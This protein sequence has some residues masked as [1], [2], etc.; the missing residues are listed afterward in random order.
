[1]KAVE[2]LWIIAGCAAAAGAPV[3]AD[4]HEPD[5][6][7]PGQAVVCVVE[8]VDVDTFIAECEADHAAIGLE[9]TVLDVIE[10]CGTYL[11][12]FDP[13]GLSQLDLDELELDLGGGYLESL[14]W[15]GF[16]YEA[17]APEGSTGSLWFYVPSGELFFE[18]QFAAG[19]F[20]LGVTHQASTGRGTVVAVLDTGID[21]AHPALAGKVLAGGFNFVD[22]NPDT[23]DVGDGL[24]TDGDGATDE[25]VGHGTY[26]ASL[27]TLIAPDAKILPV[28]VL[29]GDGV[30]STWMIAEGIYHAIEHGAEVI[31]LSLGSTSDSGVVSEAIDAAA[32]LGIVTVS[33]AGNSNRSDPEEFPAMDTAALGVAATDD[34]DVKAGFSNYNENLAITAPGASA[35]VDGNPEQYD[36]ARSIIGALPGGDYAAW[37]GTSFATAFASGAAALIRAQ[38]PEWTYEQETT[39]EVLSALTD[40]AV[41]IDA[42]NPTFIGE[43][44]EGRLDLAA[45]V[46]LGPVMPALGDL[47]NDGQVGIADF[48]ILIG[49]WGATHTSADLDG[50]GTVG[51][52][53]FLILL[54]NWG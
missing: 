41:N 8:G 11:L 5:P 30:G 38:H 20:D 33:A 1:M 29:N 21:A 47:D 31:N 48:L 14:Q 53:D 43:L 37:E 16:A 52:G 18:T 12:G 4:D 9:L 36:L 17:S 44:G 39:D 6:P 7:I 13:S 42:T 15:G 2:R 35:R 51:I 26:V 50:D 27:I 3:V 28:R 54:G 22:D 49:Y 25:L 19:L 40:S 32:A 34:L 45:A 23:S 10:P 24:D 46:A